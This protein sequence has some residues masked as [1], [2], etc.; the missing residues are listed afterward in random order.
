M[1]RNRRPRKFCARP[2]WDALFNDLMSAVYR[3][4]VRVP[5]AAEITGRGLS[6]RAWRA[7]SPEDADAWL[8]GVTD[9]EFRRWNTPVRPVETVE[10][11]DAAIRSRLQDMARGVCAAFRVTD[12]ATGDTLGFIGCNSIEH[13]GRSGRMGYWVLPEARGRRVAQRALA[14]ASTWCFTE[15]GLHRIS[16]DHALG[17]EASC[18][19]AER[20]G[21]R[22]EGVMRGEMFDAGRRDAFR[23]AHLHARLATDPEPDLA[24]EPEPE[25]GPGT[26][27]QPE[28]D[29]GSAGN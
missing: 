25:P 19:V 26:G 29:P 11:A 20:C 13:V 15:V 12:A 27:P 4:P 10:Q 22:Y 3:T 14:L 9:P 1:A 8:R 23:D 18:A 6:L 24:T 16:L 5:A 28:P 2:P 7:G 17:H 21:Y